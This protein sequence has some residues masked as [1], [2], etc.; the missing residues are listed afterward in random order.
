MQGDIPARDVSS[1]RARLGYYCNARFVSHLGSNGGFRVESYRDRAGHVCGYFDSGTMFPNT[2]HREGSGVWVVD[3]KDPKKPRLTTTLTTPAMLS[4]HESLRVNQKRGLLVAD[5]GNSGTNAGIVDVY[6]IAKDCRAP[7]LESTTPFGVLGHEGGFTPDG[8]TFYVTSIAGM[9]S[10]I[11]LRDP[12]HPNLLWV[13]RTWQPHGVSISDDGKT[14]FMASQGDLFGLR[15]LDVSQIQERVPN[16]TV[17]VIGQLTWPEVSIPQNATPF[18]SRGHHY[19]VETD[20]FGGG[21]N[22]LNAPQPV[23]AARIINVDD[24]RHPYV[25]S[26]LRLA[27]HNEGDASKTAHYCSLPSRD[28]PYIIACGFIY[29]GLRVFDVRDVAHP[30]EIAYTNFSNVPTSGSPSG[31]G[32]PGS[33]YSAPTYD[34]AHNDIWYSDASRGFFAIH[35]T[36]GSGIT[37]FAHSYMTPGS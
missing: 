17:K 25:I 16:P 10:A 7:K 22:V 26:R 34:P 5:L 32:K 13:S 19:V 4:P 18:T 3:M 28:N 31:T 8:N 12:A 30:R 35:L 11:D 9:M 21:K 6:S 29:S 1:G 14:L 37:R 15:I 24:L 2:V 23:G 33:V 20:E 36:A 27:V